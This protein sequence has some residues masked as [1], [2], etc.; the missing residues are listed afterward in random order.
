AVPTAG[1]FRQLFQKYEI[2][3]TVKRLLHSRLNHRFLH[4][5]FSQPKMA[6][7][8]HTPVSTHAAVLGV[9]TGV[10]ITVNPTL[11][12]SYWAAAISQSVRLDLPGEH[13]ICSDRA[14]TNPFLQSC[15]RVTR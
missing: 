15:I 1:R 6:A 7:A 10:A 9:V 11:Y 3:S 2:T 8:K 5:R 12:C 13:L 4:W 14:S